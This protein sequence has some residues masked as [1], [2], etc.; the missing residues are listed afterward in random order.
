MKG[1]DI[2]IL[3]KIIS[4]NESE[5]ESPAQ[6]TVR[7]LA[8]CTGV[9]KSEISAAVN[10]C[11]FAGLAKLKNTRGDVLVNRKG[12][13][14]FIHYGL[15]YVF[16]VKP[17]EVTRG[18]PTAFAAPVLNKKIYSAGDLVPVWPDG[19]AS[20]MGQSIAPLYH[21]VPDAVAR[22]QRLYG[23]LALVD[24]IR[25]GNARELNVASRELLVRMKL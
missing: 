19:N 17:A 20:Q 5:V 1:Q 23:Y 10:R 18:V 6:Y 15:K 9:S 7:S 3:L 12:L 16:P 22:D 21:S 2:L 25:I 14:E 13:Y 4:L 24:A 11:I 8:E